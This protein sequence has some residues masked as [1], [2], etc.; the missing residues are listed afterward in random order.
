[1]DVS[2]ETVIGIIGAMEQEVERIR[3]ELQEA[4][5]QV[6]A[7]IRFDAGKW[8]GKPVVV[9]RSGV[10]KVN[11]AVCTQMLIGRFGAG[12]ILFTGV[13]GAADPE[14]DIGDLVISSECVQHDMDVRPL[15]FRLGEIPYAE[16][17]VFPADRA[18]IDLALAVSREL[19]D[20]RVV[21]GRVLSG[22]Q[23]IADRAKVKEL[24]EALGGSCIEM[25]GAAVA[26]VCDMNGVPFV[27]IRSMSD[28]ADG[29]AHVNFAEFAGMAAERSHRLVSAMVE[30]LAQDA[31]GLPGRRQ[32]ASEGAPG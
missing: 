29:S 12:R 15:G 22:D 11:A 25:E 7:G 6:V 2:G 5:T 13:A 32:T 31:G 9:C 27:V 16:R 28:K 24:H 8:H 3:P 18:L 23:F 4:K 17:S 30:R 20:C 26:Q 14:L 10:G 1:M 19:F 21:V